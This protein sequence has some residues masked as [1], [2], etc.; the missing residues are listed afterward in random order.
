MGHTWKRCKVNYQIVS[1][2][3]SEDIRTCSVRQQTGYAMC[4][5]FE[6]SA[7]P[8][9]IFAVLHTSNLFSLVRI[10]ADI[11]DVSVSLPVSSPKKKKTQ[12]GQALE[13]R[14]GAAGSYMEVDSATIIQKQG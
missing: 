4:R 10:D 3:P 14:R 8:S 1:G 6:K 9:S 11:L 5:L 12:K 7:H 13:G 2:F